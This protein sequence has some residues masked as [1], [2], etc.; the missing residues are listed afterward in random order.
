MKSFKI[1]FL[2]LLGLPFL[3]FGQEQEVPPRIIN[4]IIDSTKNVGA[5]QFSPDTT[6]AALTPILGLPEPYYDF[7]WEFG[8]GHMSEEIAPTHQYDGS[9]ALRTVYL[10]ATNKYDKGKKPKKSSSFI[11]ST[12][13]R[14][15]EIEK[16]LEAA[17]ERRFDSYFPEDLEG[18]VYLKS[19]SDAKPDEDLHFMLS[20]RN[21]DTITRSGHLAI[22]FNERKFEKTMFQKR[23]VRKHYDEQAVALPNADAYSYAETQE[24]LT[25]ILPQQQDLNPAF[26]LPILPSAASISPQLQTVLDTALLTYTD[27]SIWSFDNLQPDEERNL[28]FTFHTTKEMLEDTTAF[29]HL[30]AAY[31]DDGGYSD[32]FP[33]QFEIVSAHDP[34]KVS[35]SE[36]K[37]NFR[38]FGK[39]NSLTYKIQFQNEGKGPASKVEVHA[40]IP[41][42]LDGYKVD[43]LDWHPKAPLCEDN[44]LST[45]SCISV[46]PQQD[47]AIFLFDGIY[48]PG[49]RQRGVTKKDSTKGYVKFKITPEKRIKKEPLK[50]HAGIYFDKE[51]VVL[52]N[53]TKTRFKPGLSIGIKGGVSDFRFEQTEN[54]EDRFEYAFGGIT[55][56]PFKSERFYYQGEAMLG[57]SGNEIFTQTTA[58]GEDELEVFDINGDNLFTFDEYRLLRGAIRDSIRVEDSEIIDSIRFSRERSII[59]LDI[60]PLQLRKRILPFMEVGGGIQTAF[61]LESRSARTFSGFTEGLAGENIELT[62][63]VPSTRRL[64]IIPSVFGDLSIGMVKQGPSLGLRYHYNL[65]DLQ[66]FWRVYALFKF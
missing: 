8:D 27:Q 55:L 39:N 1:T 56:S 22:L 53:Y 54:E 57:L 28:F 26:D 62:Y 40:Y 61:R 14:N 25:G 50:M 45:S 5:Y 65:R 51:P 30:L 20:Y 60:V 47:T 13:Y 66:A 2:F 46:T 38:R 58:V 16:S 32:V 19:S 34:N 42:G 11:A 17:S 36:V 33:L 31:T 24:I 35:V 52:T 18:R 48:L 23:G 6:L 7:W 9:A 29:V 63:E 49:T 12:P 59:F 10:M 37:E 41:E 64:S 44:D 21:P 3:S 43:L 4:I 15:Q